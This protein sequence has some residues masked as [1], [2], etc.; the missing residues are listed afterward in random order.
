[1]LSPSC[2]QLLKNY[3]EYCWKY[4]EKEKELRNN[5]DIII[6]EQCLEYHQLKLR[7]INKKRIEKLHYLQDNCPK[8][9][10]WC[11]TLCKNFPFGIDRPNFLFP[12]IN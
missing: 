2:S 5:S 7:K 12:P 3:L 6:R 8:L 9:Y 10:G 1:M 11:S 4:Q